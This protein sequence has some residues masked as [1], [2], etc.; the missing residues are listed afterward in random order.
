MDKLTLKQ[1][2]PFFIFEMANN[3]MGNLEHGLRIIRNI[4]EVSKNNILC[5]RENSP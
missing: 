4:H 5:M 2:K 3:H 1:A